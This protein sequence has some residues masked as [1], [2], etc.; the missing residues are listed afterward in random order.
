MSILIKNGRVIDPSQNIDAYKDILIQ[1]KHIMNLF[2][3]GK[4]PK[5]NKTID[6]SNCLVMPGLFDMHTHLREPGYEYKETIKTG[7]LAAVKGGF[8]AV[9]CMPNTNP[10]N[11]NISVTEFII[12]RAS[13]EGSCSVYPIAAV[14]MGQK[15]EALTE[16]EALLKAGCI[17]FSDDGRPVMNSL[18][19]RRALEYSKIFDVPIISHCEDLN[20]SE[21]RVMNEGFVSTILGLKGIPKA[22]EEV[23][24]AR[25]IS[26]CELTSG[27]LHIAH[28]STKGSVNL[29]RGAKERGLNITAETCPHYFSISDETLISYDTNLKVNPPIRTADDVDAIKEGLKDG[30]IDVIATDHAPHHFDDKNREFDTAAFGISGIETALQLSLRLVDSGVIN[31]MD[32]VKKMTLTPCNIMKINKG[33]LSEGADADIAI[34]NPEKE[35]TLESSQFLSKGKNSPFNKWQMKGTVEKTIVK[36]K[37]FDWT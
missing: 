22:A 26:L 34:V 3:K 30:T 19:M 16:L 31:L 2:T 32:L 11:D 29:I 13:K 28:V 36:G 12:E 23:M 17:A 21:G 6:A 37:I 35:V 14:T 5:P 7:T 9:C 20:L 8:T 24:V 18:I 1:G 4:A 27:R 33:T 25:D 10:V 15:G